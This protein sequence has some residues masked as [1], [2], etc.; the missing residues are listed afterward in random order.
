L[1]LNAGRGEIDSLTGG[2]GKDVFVLGSEYGS[3]Y[4]DGIVKNAG[5]NDY[6][7]ITDFTIGLDKLQ[8]FGAKNRYFL[9]DIT[10]SNIHNI[11]REIN[12]SGLYYDVNSNS[13]LDP[14][15]ELTAIICSANNAKLTTAN[16]VS[17]A[18]FV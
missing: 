4:D 14:K 8:L 3:L 12:G 7:L 10:S 18:Q 9:Q 16:T 15:D 6:A 17:T 13:I 11:S 5:L 1:E 2:A